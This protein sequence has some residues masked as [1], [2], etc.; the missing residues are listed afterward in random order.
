MLQRSSKTNLERKTHSKLPSQTGGSDLVK[1][2]C[3]YVSEL[4]LGRNIG[5]GNLSFLYVVSQEVVSHLNVFCSCVEH[6]VFSNAYG[7]STITK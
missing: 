2:F 1:W 7:T 5:Q 4:V 6:R 3:E